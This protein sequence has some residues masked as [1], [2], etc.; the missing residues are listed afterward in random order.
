MEYLREKNNFALKKVLLK[1]ILRKVS[2]PCAERADQFKLYLGFFERETRYN[3]GQEN[4]FSD[5][6]T[7]LL[8][9]HTDAKKMYKVFR[10]LILIK[11]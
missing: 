10:P 6:M 5:A 9:R 7:L 3:L 2:V 4:A 1:K 8:R 11:L